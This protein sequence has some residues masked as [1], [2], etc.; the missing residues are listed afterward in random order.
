MCARYLKIREHAYCIMATNQSRGE[1]MRI[2]FRT[3]SILITKNGLNLITCIFLGFFK[4]HVSSSLL[5]G[6]YYVFKSYALVLFCLLINCEM[7]LK[8][9]FF[10]KHLD[11]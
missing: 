10:F 1:N 11:C 4:L 3:E 5:F 8:I 6:C 2:L 7:H 9:K